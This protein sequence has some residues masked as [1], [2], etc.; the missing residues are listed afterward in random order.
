MTSAAGPVA[1]AERALGPDLARGFMLLFIALANSHFL[2]LG[3]EYL[4]GY[5]LDGT[6]LDAGV[7]WGLSTFVD[8][9]AYPMFGLLFGYGF[10]QIVRRQ[11]EAGTPL[12]AL[13]RM[14]WRR[15]GVLLGVGLVHSILLFGADIL[16]AY[17]VLL[18]VVGVWLLRRRDRTLLIVAALFLVVGFVPDGGAET[19]GSQAPEDF[20]VPPD[21]E[22]LLL[23]R[24][25]AAWFVTLL[26]PLGFVCPFAVG[27][28][29]GRRR[30]LEWPAAHRNL[31]MR[32][33]VV[34]L[35]AAVLGAQPFALT[36]AGVLDVSDSTTLGLLRALQAGTGVLGGC[37]YAAL[38]A[39]LAQRMRGPFVDALA[40]TGQRSMSCYL[41]QSLVWT[42]AYTPFLLGLS[43][44]VGV[45]GCALIATA[46]WAAT[47][48]WANSL[49]RRGKRGPFEVL[50]RRAT[51]R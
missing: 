42:L 19:I 43:D 13:R 24:A 23:A 18:A 39:L 3:A 10:A 1:L 48:W 34:G 36:I 25:E 27:M 46:T 50:V 8:G 26:G 5:P 35:G 45:A 49:Q 33:A 12:R 31:L 17:G 15:S 7:A 2:L 38:I 6:V 30:V 41:A 32:T 22:T 29:A 28:W 44:D 11:W 4:G 21:L 47:V 14:L 20:M 37:G 16:R 40:A 9:R 51:Y